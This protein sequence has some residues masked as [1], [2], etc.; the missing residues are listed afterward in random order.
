LGRAGAPPKVNGRWSDVEIVVA[1]SVP[2]Y[3]AE[4]RIA[5]ELPLGSL[6]CVLPAA[7]VVGFLVLSGTS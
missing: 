4:T 5:T 3:S 6:V 2:A 1:E 7:I